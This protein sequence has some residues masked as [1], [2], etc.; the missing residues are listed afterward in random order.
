MKEFTYRISPEDM[1]KPRCRKV[2]AMD[3][4]DAR[5]IICKNK[6]CKRYQIVF[7]ECKEIKFEEHVEKKA[8]R[9][10]R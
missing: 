1:I 10:R 8:K 2:Y 3:A 5:N 6:R 7:V 9:K 4:E